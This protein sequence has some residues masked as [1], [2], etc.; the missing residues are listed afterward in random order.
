MDFS[1]KSRA[2]LKQMFSNTL[3]DG[4]PGLCFSPYVEGQ[5]AGDILSE[6]QIRRRM[7]IIMPYTK[8]IRTFSCTEG[9]ELI[10][11][12]AKEKGLKTMVGAWISADRQRNEIELRTLAQ[13]AQDGLVDIAAIGNEVLLRNELSAAEII[14]YLKQARA[15]LPSHVPIGYVDAYYH[16][17]EH[18]EIVDACDV[19]LIN[20]YPFWEGADNAHALAYLQHMYELTQGVAKGKPIIIAETGWPSQ[21]E[22]VLEAVPSPENAIKYFLN[23]QQWAKQHAVEVFYFSSFDESWKVQQEGEV[24]RSWGLWNNEEKLKYG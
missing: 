14:D 12:I 4:L 22:K 21:G 19:I 20:C 24:G 23:V 5:A 16:F 17:L 13:L 2:E 3:R 10:P 11:R 9:N 1:A 15:L 18:P 7:E 8:A 6:E